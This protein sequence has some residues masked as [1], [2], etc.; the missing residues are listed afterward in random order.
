MFI[1]TWEPTQKRE[2]KWMTRTKIIK[3]QKHKAHE[4]TNA[5]G[6]SRNTIITALRKTK[7]DAATTA[8]TAARSQNTNINPLAQIL[9][10]APLR[11]QDGLGGSPAATL[12][13]DSIIWLC[14]RVQGLIAAGADDSASFLDAIGRCLIL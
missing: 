2:K 8:T 12:T 4:Q 7:K 6:K 13:F 5:P 14:L 10:K 11:R 1:Y 9:G 3:K